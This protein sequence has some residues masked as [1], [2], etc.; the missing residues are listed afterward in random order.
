MTSNLASEEIANYAQEL[1]R[2]EKKPSL[3]I[4]SGLSLIEL[5]KQKK[6]NFIQM[7]LINNKKMMEKVV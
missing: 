4:P 2:E 7:I 1:R 5:F 6:S 3:T